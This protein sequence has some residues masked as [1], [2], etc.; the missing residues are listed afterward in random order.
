MP[1]SI[2]VSVADFSAELNGLTLPMGLTL[3]RVVLRGTT[4][5]WQKHPFQFHLPNPGTFE[6]HVTQEELAAFLLA[7]FLG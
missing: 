3:S 5:T 1:S 6:A 4:L 7:V 2:S